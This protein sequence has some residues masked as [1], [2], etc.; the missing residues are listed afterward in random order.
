MKK[1]FFKITHWESGKEDKKRV[2]YVENVRGISLEGMNEFANLLDAGF[3]RNHIIEEIEL[4][5]D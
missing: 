4:D 2:F 1:K 5:E 3:N